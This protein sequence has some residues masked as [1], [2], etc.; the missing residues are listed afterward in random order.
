MD[1]S[2]KFLWRS[3]LKRHFKKYIVKTYC[4]SENPV[5]VPIFLY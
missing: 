3:D 4:N 2:L 1:E 5:I